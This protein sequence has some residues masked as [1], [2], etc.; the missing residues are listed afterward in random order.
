MFRPASSGTLTETSMETSK[1][2]KTASTE[3]KLSSLN[4]VIRLECMVGV[5]S[6]ENRAFSKLELNATT[7]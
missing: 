4:P 2:S 1:Y 5:A 7:S 3:T 6:V